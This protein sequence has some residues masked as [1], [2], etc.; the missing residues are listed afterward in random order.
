MT[1]YKEIRLPPERQANHLFFFLFPYT[2]NKIR[3]PIF[4]QFLSS[5]DCFIKSYMLTYFLKWL[6]YN[7]EVV[8]IRS[9]FITGTDTDVGKT[10]VTSLLT[11]FLIDMGVNA[12][13]YKPV[14][15]GATTNG[16]RMIPSDAQMY[17]LVRPEF[18]VTDFNTYL[19]EKPCSPHL[20]ADLA[21]ITLDRTVIT[22][23][24]HQLEEAHDAVLIEGA[25]GLYVP[26]TNDGY[27]YIDFMEEL[28]VPTILVSALRVGTINHTVLSIEAMKARN[29]P[30]A[31]IIFNQLQIGNPVIEQSNVETIRKLTDT[32]ILGFVPYSPDIHTVLADDKLRRHLYKDW[33]KRRFK[34]LIHSD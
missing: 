23:Q 11:R 21:N 26:L 24:V 10:V 8:I 5:F 19:L 12:F 18:D 27:C 30:I 7:Q 17:Q 1:A 15:S 4:T 22:K 31:G 13:P 25:G 33:D 6:T 2:S 34:E 28:N 32:P 3:S 9:F 20:A 29:L 14:Q 16:A